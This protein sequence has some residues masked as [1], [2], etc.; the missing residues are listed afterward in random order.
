MASSSTVIPVK[1]LHSSTYPAISPSRPELSQTGRTV[2]VTGGGAGVG[3][4]IAAAFARAGASTIILT[5]RREHVLRSAA[6]KLKA[7]SQGPNTDLKIYTHAVDVASVKSVADLWAWLGETGIVVDVVVS[8]AGQGQLLAQSVLEFGLDQAWHMYEVNVRAHLALAVHLEKQ[9]RD[10]SRGPTVL[11]NV[12]SLSAW[13]LA[14]SAK[15][16]VYAM[17]KNTGIMLMQQIAIHMSADKMR[18]ISFHPGTIS[19]PGCREFLT[20]NMPGVDIPFDSSELPGEFAVWLA[21]PEAAFLHGRF[22]HANWDIDELKSGEVRK[23]ID[24]DPFYLKV[25]ILGLHP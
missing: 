8:N 9:Q 19:T 25:G 12:A 18:V 17:T 15:M 5:G 13:H 16:P 20:K 7:E 1:T 14:V 24:E 22:V 3:Y 23:H 21:S 2:L 11:I 4:Y 6:D 10:P